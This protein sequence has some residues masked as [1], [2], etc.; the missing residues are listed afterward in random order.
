MTRAHARILC[1]FLSEVGSVGDSAQPEITVKTH[2]W[3]ALS[4][5]VT[6][7]HTWLFELIKIKQNL[8]ARIP[9]PLGALQGLSNP[10]RLPYWTAPSGFLLTD[11]LTDS[12]GPEA[13][14]LSLAA[15][16]GWI[17]FV[18]FKL[19]DSESHVQ[20]LCL[21]ASVRSTVKGKVGLL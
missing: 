7:S 20:S 6:T 1:P 21:R 10:V 18:A 11:V 17:L 15:R 9:V 4:D 5:T 3:S 8:K 14:W 12:R 19:G 2:R 13:T 16:Q